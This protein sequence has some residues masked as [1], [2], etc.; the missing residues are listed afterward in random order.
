MNKCILLFLVMLLPNL[1]EAAEQSPS[2][3]ACTVVQEISTEDAALFERY[4][5]SEMKPVEKGWD[6]ELRAEYSSSWG[7]NEAGKRVLRESIMLLA[8]DG[9]SLRRLSCVRFDGSDARRVNFRE[10]RQ[11]AVAPHVFMSNLVDI[12]DDGEELLQF[13]IVKLNSESG[14]PAGMEYVSFR[15]KELLL[16]NEALTEVDKTLVSVLF[17]PH[18]LRRTPLTW[19]ASRRVLYS[20][21]G[22]A[23]GKSN[24]RYELVA[25]LKLIPADGSS[26]RVIQKAIERRG[27]F[28]RTWRGRANSYKMVQPFVFV[29]MPSANHVVITVEHCDSGS[30]DYVSTVTREYAFH[31]LELVKESSVQL[32]K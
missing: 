1:S 4:F 22:W 31:S 28:K 23:H 21:R 14:K 3:S 5:G 27:H 32:Q 13:N 12:V 19:D 20:A 24:P 2:V 15:K 29:H 26:C 11:S 17:P 30:G 6:D 16:Q 25:H 8:A 7:K 10:I 9:S 18:K